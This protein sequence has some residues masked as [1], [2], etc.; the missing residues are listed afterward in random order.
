MS[1]TASVGI[2]ISGY[3]PDL[4]PGD[5]LFVV[6]KTTEGTSVA[7]PKAAAQW[8]NAVHGG[9]RGVYHYARPAAG[10]TPGNVATALRQANV[11]A[12]DALSR[13]FRRGVDLWQLDCEG[14]LNDGVTSAG[15]SAFVPAFMDTATAK[16]GPLGFLYV[17]RYFHWDAFDP[18][19][20]RYPWWLPDYG[21][22]NGQVH[23]L[24][25]GANPV[26]HQFSAAGG[27]DRNVIHDVARWNA[28][29]N[30][31]PSPTVGR[32]KVNPDYSPPASAQAMTPFLHPNTALGFKGACAALVKPDGA[33]FCEP[34]AAYLGGMNGDPDF[35]GRIAVDLRPP[36]KAERDKGWTVYGYVIVAHTGETYYKGAP[37]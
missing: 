10:G 13:G 22:N 25:A 34:S 17:G 26:I 29:T 4:V 33:V 28:M 19:V 6:V 12:D 37:K 27:L 3:Q 23:P 36:N 21:P 31:K 14:A 32:L 20:A 30:T 7:N 11:F 18:L 9:R 24:P 35:A 8:A 16:L 5:W 15:W 1:D 2:D